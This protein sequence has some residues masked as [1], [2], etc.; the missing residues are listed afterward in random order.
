MQASSSLSLLHSSCSPYLRS[1]MIFPPSG[2]SDDAIDDL[3]WV[4]TE[5]SRRR[6]GHLDNLYA[7]I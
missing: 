6:R 1:Y 2:F 3:R 7:S 4:S 5:T